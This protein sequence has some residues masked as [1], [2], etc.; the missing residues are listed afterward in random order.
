MLIY[1]C[2]LV[3]VLLFGVVCERSSGLRVWVN[4]NVTSWFVLSVHGLSVTVDREI[5]SL[6]KFHMG[7]CFTKL[8]LMEV[9]Y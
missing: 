2:C 8:K 9:F 4:V 3:S 6:Y 7:Q 1:W 5:L